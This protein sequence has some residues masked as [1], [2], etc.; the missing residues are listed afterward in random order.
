ML[1]DFI[2]DSIKR[3]EEKQQPEQQEYAY[4]DLPPIEIK[5]EPQQDDKDRGVTIIEFF[6]ND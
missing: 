4:V 1:P 3:R 2:I 5:Q 6:D